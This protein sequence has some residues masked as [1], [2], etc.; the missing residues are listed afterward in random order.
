MKNKP[1]ALWHLFERTG[2]IEAY[3]LYAGIE[4]GEEE[5]KLP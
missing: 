3:L 2:N 4:S 5:A 1:Q